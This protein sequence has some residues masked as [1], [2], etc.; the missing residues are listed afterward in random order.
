MISKGL[1]YLFKFECR[2]NYALYPFDTQECSMVMKLTASPGCHPLLGESDDDITINSTSSTISMYAATELHYCVIRDNPGGDLLILH[3]LLSRNYQSHLLTIFLPCTILCYLAHLTLTNFRLENFTNR[4]SVTLSLLIVLASLFSQMSVSLPQS[5]EPK[6]VDI[7]FFYCII[8]VSFVFVIHIAVESF[9][10]KESGNLSNSVE[11]ECKEDLN[12]KLAW[13]WEN[14]DP[15][16]ESPK[17]KRN[18]PKIINRV[19]NIF[20]LSVDALAI[21]G[22]IYWAVSDHNEKHDRFNSFLR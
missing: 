18:V 20:S 19:G 3:F 10:R 11:S 2:Y 13:F 16:I 4:I 7:F 22:F 17:P 5:P 6:L 15:Q 21:C 9:L 1:E 14:R 12:V 8:R